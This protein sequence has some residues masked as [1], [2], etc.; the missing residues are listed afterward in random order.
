M[1]PTNIY[2]N[3]IHNHKCDTRQ[4]FAARAHASIERVTALLDEARSTTSPTLGSERARQLL[5]DVNVVYGTIVRS[6]VAA[7]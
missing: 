6:A 5:E 4:I 3:I 2:N 1:R 7:A